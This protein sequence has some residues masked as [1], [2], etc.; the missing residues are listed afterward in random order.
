MLIS[1]TISKP[2]CSGILT[3]PLAPGTERQ[4]LLFIPVRPISRTLWLHQYKTAATHSLSLPLASSVLFGIA[5]ALALPAKALTLTEALGQARRS[6]PQYLSAQASHTAT[7]ERSNQAFGALLP[8]LSV[9]ANTTANQRRYETKSSTIPPTDDTYNSSSAQLTLNQHLWHSPSRIAST[10]ADAALNQARYQLAL[11]EQDLL[12]RLAQAWFDAMVARDTVVFCDRQQEATQHQWEQ[13]RRAAEN[14]LVT[15]PMLQDA[16]SKYDQ[17]LAEQASAVSDLSIKLAAL[18]QIIGAIAA[19]PASTLNTEFQVQDPRSKTLEQWLADAEAKHPGVLAATN[20]LD[21]ANEEIRKQEAGHEPTLAAVATYGRNGQTAGSF[22][23]QNGYEITQYSVGLQLNIPLYSGGTQS[24]KV[25]EAI[26]LKDRATQDLESAKR[27]ARLMV[28]QAW[29]T[30]HSGAARQTAALQASRFTTLALQA[31]IKGKAAGVKTE[32][33]VLQARQQLANSA[34][35]LHKARYEMVTSYLKLQAA[36]GQLS[37]VDLT[38]I[39][40]WLVPPE[41]Q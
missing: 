5:M 37:D 40:A 19:P 12:V 16:R 22:P 9:A 10:Q 36:T 15:G 41:S 3:A 32:L 24:A 7:A 2:A 11:A 27:N 1:K 21:A 28:K 4:T 25:R 35:D 34:R 38:S 18:E 31:A 14:G 26:A 29:F 13:A 8:Q 17:A 39:D 30:W 20:A 23:G 33:D 6:D